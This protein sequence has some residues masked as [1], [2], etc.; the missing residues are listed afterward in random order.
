MASESK[1]RRADSEEDVTRPAFQN[2][3]GGLNTHVLMAPKQDT[4][5]TLYRGPSTNASHS[6]SS[7]LL[8][9]SHCANDLSREFSSGPQSITLKPRKGGRKHNVHGLNF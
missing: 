5:K 4:L 3:R 2:Q 8:D 9:Y 6:R 1:A 7:D